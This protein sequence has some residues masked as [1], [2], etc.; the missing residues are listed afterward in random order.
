MEH[1][2]ECVRENGTFFMVSSDKNNKIESP[3]GPRPTST[4]IL[5]IL[6]CELL[7]VLFRD[8]LPHVE[9]FSFLHL[10]GLVEVDQQRHDAREVEHVQVIFDCYLQRC[11]NL[12]FGGLS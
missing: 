7:L 11:G 8:L 9:E 2:R 3:L 10:T 5:G 1:I 4:Q 12:N 6:N